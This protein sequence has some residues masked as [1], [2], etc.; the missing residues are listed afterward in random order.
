MKLKVIY[1]SA[2]GTTLRIATEI[3][4]GIGEDVEFIDLTVPENRLN[5]LV[6]SPLDIVLFAFP[7]YAGRVVR[8]PRYFLKKIKGNQAK[9]VSV[10]TY[11]NRAYDDALLELC[12]L[13]ENAG[14]NHIAAG[15]FICEHAFDIGLATRRPDKDDCTVAESFGREIKRRLYNG[16]YKK[17]IVPNIPG[18]YPFK[19]QFRHD[20]GGPLVPK[21]Y[22]NCSNCGKCA[23][24]CPTEAISLSNPQKTDIKKCIT[25]FRCIRQCPNDAR[26][27][28]LDD[29]QSHND[30]LNKTYQ[31]RKE[32]EMFYTSCESK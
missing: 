14:F 7:V 23:K 16:Q 26:K 30:W 13:V 3:A 1:F 17:T 28:I 29:F 27:I 9:A 12:M 5:D 18:E 4:E 24:N 21:T 6:F 10:V 15:A 8:I 2:M 32:P 11:G 31:K 22:E 19:T 25:C 20:F